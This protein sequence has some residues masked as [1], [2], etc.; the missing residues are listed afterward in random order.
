[1]IIL[2]VFDYDL[3]CGA[4]FFSI[5]LYGVPLWHVLENQ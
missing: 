3:H 1:M 2:A 4:L 5:R